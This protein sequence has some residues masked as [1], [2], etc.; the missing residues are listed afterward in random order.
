MAIG[1]TGRAV[2]AT[3]L[4]LMVG[5]ALALSGCGR[6]TDAPGVASAGGGTEAAVSPTPSASADRDEQ[7]RRFAQCMRNHGVDM[8]DPQPGGGGLGSG[9]NPS[10]PQVQSGFTACQSKLPG[11]G[12]PPKLN[13]Q[14]AEAYRAFAS[15]MRDNGVDLPDPAADGTLQFNVKNLGSLDTGSPTFTSA[16][17][18]C[19][20]KLTSLMASRT[21]GAS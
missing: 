12:Q 6:S 21:G 7:L 8:P 4:V 16:M 2:R 9:L 1:R 13:P 14:Q 10:D 15:C 3:A 5:L 11:G 20:D 18:A 19:R 17:T